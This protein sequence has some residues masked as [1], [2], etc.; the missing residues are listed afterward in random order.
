[1]RVRCS[2][3]GNEQVI[4]SHASS[5]VKCSVCSKT[6]AIPRGGKAEIKTSIIEVLR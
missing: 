5:V 3:C 1:M 2:E 4:F 6:L